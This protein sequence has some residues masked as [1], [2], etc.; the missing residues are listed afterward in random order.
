MANRNIYMGGDKHCLRYRVYPLEAWGLD[1]FV[2]E[3]CVPSAAE[4]IREM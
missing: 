2:F 4:Q 3:H 1:A